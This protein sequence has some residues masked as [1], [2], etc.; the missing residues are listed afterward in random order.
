MCAYSGAWALLASTPVLINPDSLGERGYCH[1][2]GSGCHFVSID[3]PFIEGFCVPLLFAICDQCFLSVIT[4]T[5]TATPTHT[6]TRTCAHAGKRRRK[7]GGFIGADVILSQFK[8]KPQWKRVGLASSGP[9]A[10]RE[11]HVC[12]IHLC[13]PQH[14]FHAASLGIL[15]GSQLDRNLI[16]QTFQQLGFHHMPLSHIDHG[17]ASQTVAQSQQLVWLSRPHTCIRSVNHI[18]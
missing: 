1:P 2:V 12:T 5:P 6:L 18:H 10:R 13:K 14:I 15:Y 7:E 4:D 16:S 11:W 17:L 8:G 9:V 3:H